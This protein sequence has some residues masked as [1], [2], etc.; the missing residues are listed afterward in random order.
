M[1]LKIKKDL[2]RVIEKHSLLIQDIEIYAVNALINWLHIKN[3][4]FELHRD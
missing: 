3:Q 1:I 4:L 2:K